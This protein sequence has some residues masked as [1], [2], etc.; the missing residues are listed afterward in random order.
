MLP[1]WYHRIVYLIGCLSHQNKKVWSLAC[2]HV[3]MCTEAGD[4]RMTGKST[5]LFAVCIYG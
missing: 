5:V 4:V 3:R 1:G 2:V